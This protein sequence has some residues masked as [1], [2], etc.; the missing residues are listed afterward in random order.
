M[1]GQSDQLQQGQASPPIQRQRP[2]FTGEWT[3]G[4]CLIV[5]AV[6]VIALVISIAVV[7]WAMVMKLKRAGFHGR[8]TRKALVERRV[9]QE[10]V[11]PKLRA[12][13]RQWMDSKDRVTEVVGML[14]YG[15]HWLA[16]RTPRWNVLTPPGGIP[17]PSVPSFLVTTSD[18]V[19]AKS[20]LTEQAMSDIRRLS[21]AY[22]EALFLD[23]RPGQ[24]VI[25][26]REPENAPP[27][28]EMLVE[29]A[30]KLAEHAISL[31]GEASSSNVQAQVGRCG[32]CGSVVTPVRQ[33]VCPACNTPHH[34]EC[35]AYNEGCSMYG[36]GSPPSRN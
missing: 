6:L 20:F 34:R 21:D 28:T 32:V 25:R 12:H 15:V 29:H 5:A 16:I 36:C 1:R 23:V 33:L 7:H 14:P 19:W 4:E 18:P 9:I 17:V 3:G 31:M 30:T 8:T 10:I 26:V 22:Y 11:R 27:M 2:A 24:F 13:V 35:W